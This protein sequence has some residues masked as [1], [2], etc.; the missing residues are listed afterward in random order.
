MAFTDPRHHEPL[1]EADIQ[2]YADGTLAPERAAS[3]RRYLE[4]RP[5]EARRIAFY[6][7]L[8]AQMQRAFRPTDEPSTARPFTG[9]ERHSA[10]RQLWRR[11]RR[12]IAVRCALALT[13]ALLT[14]S[15]WIAASQVGAQAL[16]NAAVMALAET[17]HKHLPMPTDGAMADA[18]DAAPDLTM[19][20]L[21]LAARKTTTVNRFAGA[22]EFIYLNADGQPV[23]LLT[24]RSL[25][26]P[27]RPQW[28]A[29]RIGNI[30][31]LTWTTRWQR[32]VLA[33]EAETHGLMRAA[34]ALTLR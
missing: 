16:N 5:N 12:S 27:A 6:G 17:A 13:L 24:A 33:G 20:G 9:P 7:R 34:D 32:Y 26:V 14:G 15:G 3:L 1:S 4:T 31:L 22:D 8:N 25:T 28:A 11:L 2:A 30:R 21:R 23:I 18:R 10:L 29:R 19:A